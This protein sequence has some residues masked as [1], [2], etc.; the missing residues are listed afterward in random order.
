MLYIYDGTNWKKLGS[1]G[2]GDKALSGDALKDKSIYSSKIGDINIGKISNSY[3]N[4]GKAEPWGV[5]ENYAFAIDG[6]NTAINLK[7]GSKDRGITFPVVINRSDFGKINLYITGSYYTVDNELMDNIVEIYILREDGSIISPAIFKGSKNATFVNIAL[8]PKFIKDNKIANN[9][10]ILFV[11]HGGKGTLDVSNPQISSDYANTNLST[12]FESI[13]PLMEQN[14]LKISEA[15]AA[16][17]LDSFYR[18]PEYIIVKSSSD[19]NAVIRIPGKVIPGKTNEIELEYSAIS[20]ESGS[21]SSYLTQSAKGLQDGNYIHIGEVVPN[22]GSNKIKYSLSVDEMKKLGIEDDVYI[23]TGGKLST[24]TL[25]G[26][27]LR[28]TNIG[29]G[30]LSAINQLGSQ[31]KDESKIFGGFLDKFENYSPIDVPG[32]GLVTC[33][34]LFSENK[35]LNKISIYSKKDI[36]TKFY[37]GKLDQNNL[38]VDSKQYDINL[39][40]GVNT[41]NFEDKNIDVNAGEYVFVDGAQVGIYKPTHENIQ[42]YTTR[43]QDDKHILTGQYSGKA[44]YE[45]NYLVPF[46]YTVAPATDTQKISDLEKEIQRKQEIIDEQSQKIKKNSILISPTGEKLKLFVDKEGNV[47]TKSVVP[48]NVQVF[49]N[50]LTSYWYMALGATDDRHD[51]YAYVMDYIQKNNPKAII[52]KRNNVAQWE[53]INQVKNRQEAFE[54]LIKPQLSD[55]TDMVFLQLGDNVNNEERHKTFKEDIMKLFENIRE[56][57]PKAKIIFIGMWFCGWDDMIESVKEA[58]EKYDGNFVDIRDLAKDPKNDA[59]IGEVCT[60]PDGST[61]TITTS[62]EAGHPGNEGYKKIANRVISNLDF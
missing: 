23:Y 57:S 46:S 38:L 2:I 58:C 52:G 35:K 13:S 50:S 29:D 44:F 48:N 26:A 14:Q 51:W 12:K 19:E 15:T 20:K 16:S 18:T 39:T 5:K 42:T 31:H 45:G 25:T 9:F 17:E 32:L 40:T 28:A 22:T 24:L 3:I 55:D 62:G 33:G 6:N 59:Y 1:A 10:K 56:V 41:F 37:I 61:K 4:I 47:S 53:Q 43:L 7:E 49:G 21:I 30:V 54:K 34:E 27:K 36:K 60:L 11:A 8:T